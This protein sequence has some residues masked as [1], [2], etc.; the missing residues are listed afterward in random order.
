MTKLSPDDKRAEVLKSSTKLMRDMLQTVNKLREIKSL[1]L[2]PD[3][4]QDVL[5]SFI[6]EVIA[7]IDGGV[8][9]L[10]ET[11]T[12]AT[13]QRTHADKVHA[14]VLASLAGK[15]MSELGDLVQKKAVE[16][17]S[18]LAFQGGPHA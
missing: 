6:S 11:Y 13:S 4:P 14:I 12:P 7:T 9:S 16:G 10:L 1:P 15:L 17:L 8:W 2:I 5:E 3:V 18:A